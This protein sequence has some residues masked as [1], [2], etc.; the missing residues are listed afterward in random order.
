M[1]SSS[2]GRRGRRRAAGQGAPAGSRAGSPAPPPV[3]AGRRVAD[4]L[5]EWLR[6]A[7]DDGDHRPSTVAAYRMVVARHIGP[8]LGDVELGRLSAYDLDR[9]YAAK[10]AEGLAPRTIKLHHA[11]LSSALSR[12]VRW[13]WLARSPALD[14]APPRVPRAEQAAPTVAEVRA[15]LDT[16]AAEGDVDLVTLVALAAITGARRGELAGLRWADVDLDAGTVTIARQRLPLRGGDRTGPLKHGDRRRVA[17]DAATVALLRRYRARQAERAV[18]AGEP[19]PGDGWLLSRDWGATPWRALALN[20][21]VR[22]LGERAGVVVTPHR[23]RH[24][25][26][27][28]M[29]AAG[30]DPVTAARRLGHTPEV[31]LRTYAYHLP[32]RD[33]DAARMLEAGVLGAAPPG[34]TTP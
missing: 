8:A 23:L 11:V 3:G 15:L 25:A 21:A 26:A 16:A 34:A 6:V 12:A 17:I 1:T 27:T 4:L 9:Y 20:E 13:G 19:A 24:F 32:E 29:V 10:R 30:I 31:M 2:E 33:R 18:A 28:Q 22:A 5:E 14:A 7:I